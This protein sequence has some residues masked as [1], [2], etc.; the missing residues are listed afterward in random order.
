MGNKLLKMTLFMKNVF[1][2]F[3]LILLSYIGCNFE[4][5]LENILMGNI[6]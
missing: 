3:K 2:F 5:K 1:F 4:N 6:F